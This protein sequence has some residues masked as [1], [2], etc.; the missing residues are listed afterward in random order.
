VFLGVVN[1]EHEP[2]AVVVLF[3]FLWLIPECIY[4]SND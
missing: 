2:E 1:A 4:V 3:F